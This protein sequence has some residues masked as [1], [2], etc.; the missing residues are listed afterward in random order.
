MWL[1]YILLINIFLIYH[2]SAGPK[3]K[4]NRFNDEDFNFDDVVIPKFNS[5][6][7]SFRLPNNTVPIHYD[8]SLL[9]D[10]HVGN[11]DFF[12]TVTIDLRVV[13]QTE[14]ITVHYRQSTVSSID[15]LNI[16]G[17]L[18]E[19]NVDYEQIEEVE[20]LVIK[21]RTRLI[22]FNQYKVVIRYRAVLRTDDYGFYRA[23]YLNEEGKRIWVATTQFQATDARH[24]FPW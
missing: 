12:G 10:I 17:Q 22:V 21:P 19:S 23:S 13:E 20:F 8:I 9:T 2:A 5:S 6:A 16:N 15:L 3:V 1:K 11:F 7:L 14:T 4:I 18:I 24:A